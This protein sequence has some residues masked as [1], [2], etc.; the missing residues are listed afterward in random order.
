VSR[1]G[2]T[3]MPLNLFRK[4]MT[5]PFCCNICEAAQTKTARPVERAAVFIQRSVFYFG[6]STITICLPSKRGSL[7]TLAIGSV[8]ALTR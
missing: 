7:S 8:S 2:K 5:M 3:V 4:R 6:A 1:T